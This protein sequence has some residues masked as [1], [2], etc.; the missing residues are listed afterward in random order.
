MYRKE[1]LPILQHL[2][3]REM[4]ST[5]HHCLCPRLSSDINH[6]DHSPAFLGRI[7]DALGL[8]LYLKSKGLGFVI[9][10]TTLHKSLFLHERFTTLTSADSQVNIS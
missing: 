4:P 3:M 5:R 6:L 10:F 1:S 8:S 2:F 7:H 9:H